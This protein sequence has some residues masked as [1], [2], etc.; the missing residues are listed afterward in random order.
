MNALWVLQLF[1]LLTFLLIRCNSVLGEVQI[2]C[3]ERERRVLLKIKDELTDDYGH[4]S[5]WGN[6][7]DKRECCKWRGIRC[8]KQSGHVNLI[9]LQVT[10][11]SDINYAPLR[12]KI[13]HSLIQLKHLKVL[14]LKCN[15]F[16]DQL[17]I[18]EFIGFLTAS[19][20]YLDLSLS[21]FGGSFPSQIGNLSTLK[22]LD[23]SC[24]NFL[25]VGDIESF[26]RL[27][28]LEH[29][30]L[31]GNNLS[32]ATD[33]LY[34][35]N[36]LPSL[37]TLILSSCGLEDVHLLSSLSY[38]NSSSSS[39]SSSL[40]NLNL[41]ANHFSAS[42]IYKWL[43]KIG[44]NLMH[45]NLSANPLQGSIP[46]EF[47]DVMFSLEHLDLDFSEL[48]DGIPKSMGNLCELHTLR[49][50]YNNLSGKFEDF[51]ANMSGC[52]QTSL[53]VLS[54]VGN[55]LSGT[56]SDNINIFSSLKELY[57][58]HNCLNGTL[59]KTS[60]A[61]ISILNI[62]D[63]S[64][65]SLEGSL[66]NLSLSFPSL[67]K[68]YLVG[69]QFTGNPTNSFSHLFN[70]EA[71]IIGNNSFKGTLTEAC[72]SKLSRLK[73]L[74]L[75]S[76]SHQLYL[77]ISSYWIPPFQLD[78]L[79]LES[80]NLGP[81]FPNWFKT[82]RNFS[83][84]DISNN[85]ISD[86]IPTWFWNL[87]PKVTFLDLSHNQFSGKL[88]DLSTLLAG[89]RK[90]DV[91]F[92]N[93]EGLLP[94][95]PSNLTYLNLSKNRFSGSLQNICKIVALKFLDL[96]DNMLSGEIPN[97]QMKCQGLSIL[98]LANNN[99]SGKI[100]SSIGTLSKLELLDLRDNSLSGELPSSL[101]RCKLLELI[102][103]GNNKFS[104]EIPY[105]IGE[106]LSHLNFL[107]LRSNEFYGEIPLQMC[108]LSKI[109]IL[110]LS[111]NNISGIIPECF[112][113][114]SSMH[115]KGNLTTA[116]RISYFSFSHPSG[117][118]FGN[119]YYDGQVLV[120]TEGRKYEYGRSRELLRIIDL[121]G[122]K[123]TGNIPSQ[124]TNLSALVALNLSR[125]S[126][127]GT[128]P[129][130]IGMLKELLSLD[131]SR[132]HLSGNI[133]SS[134]A[135]F[136]F[137]N[138]L[139]LSYNYFS[140][141]IPSSTQLQSFNASQFI[142]NTLLCGLPLPQKCPG[143]KS[144]DQSQPTNNG[145]AGTVQEDEDE[146]EK[147]FYIGMG[148]GFA[149]GFWVICSALVLKRSWRHAYFLL[150]IN[151]KDRVYVTIALQAERLRRRFQS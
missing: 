56:F 141:K 64:K 11:C 117:S 97:C 94:L 18:S 145:G 85:E 2:K 138:R 8:A 67:T 114:F 142:G 128:I 70:L 25:N 17:D 53:Q 63:L 148:I 119:L 39:F 22:Y 5:S 82:Q 10:N 12:G 69:N 144:L 118:S 28:S 36:K 147:W 105:W 14:D 59:F 7:D 61:P 98:N 51:I 133:P 120:L 146:F 140:G 76:N 131:L 57:V 9:N 96:S 93:L 136:T 129:P 87:S 115:Q 151:I 72:L 86:T 139:D 15:D 80:C 46:D 49:M 40:E 31:S 33:S 92:N 1:L 137:L 37:K 52:T 24:N 26:S 123:L 73:Q 121:S 65:N 91:G 27:S 13:N 122:N 125:N 62:L 74:Y 58:A 84:F 30:D 32:A 83:F 3:I 55:Q 126:L 41:H 143:D 44:K 23:L 135:D 75:S 81:K 127:N 116:H 95:L 77:R 34:V 6:E 149:V 102:D 4:L 45:L 16:S 130:K 54:L 88:P 47:G 113:N 48:R 79:H 110:D 89:C 103:L 111:I 112:I 106:S 50:D 42:V 78:W 150:M 43:F 107:I 124:L 29:L 60:S 21:H 38:F 104:G 109:K 35:V 108:Q 20:S 100:P 99:L 90:I 71:L 132:N 66:P 101:E 134:M 19:L 68:L